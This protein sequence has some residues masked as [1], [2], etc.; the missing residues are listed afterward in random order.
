[1]ATPALSARILIATD[2]VG[3]A[4][5]VSGILNTEF[6]GVFTTTDND[7]AVEDFVHHKPDVLV[8][9][10]NTLEKSERCY[11]SMYRLCP[12]IH[13]QP[14]R[15]VILSSKEEV[16]RAYELCMKDIF[17]D[18]I[19]FWP[20]TYDAPR[21]NL[22][23]HNALRELAALKAVGHTVAE[24]AVHARP[25]SEMEQMLD[26]QPVD[27]SGHS[28]TKSV[29]EQVGLVR[30]NILVVDDDDFQHKLIGKLLEQ[31]DFHLVFASSG[32]EALRITRK[33]PPDLIL[34]DVM[35]PDMD[36]LETM[37]NLKAEPKF[38]KIPVIMITGKSDGQVV[39]NSMKVGAAD[40]VV[41][42]FNKAT[43]IAKVN[44]AL[45]KAKVD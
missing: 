1:M 38:A 4:D 17:D 34:M 43:L 29:A 39:S 25:L 33:A 2:I 21:L 31:K 6:D 28:D 44:H 7:H 13:L 23:V 9:A 3:D 42:P 37:R 10:F 45:G 26:L 12:E 11:L 18:Y 36:G 32:R 41:K 40:F 14:H 5:L 8:L 22:A 27:A 24:F 15:T 20:M 35:M 19:L 30:P 16:R